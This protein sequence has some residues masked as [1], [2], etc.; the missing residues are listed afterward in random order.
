MGFLQSR[1]SRFLSFRRWRGRSSLVGIV[2]RRRFAF[3]V[4]PSGRVEVV[5]R[6]ARCIHRSAVADAFCAAPRAA[7]SARTYSMPSPEALSALHV[8]PCRLEKWMSSSW[9]LNP[10]SSQMLS[11]AVVMARGKWFCS[12]AWAGVAGCAGWV[13]RAA[14]SSMRTFSPRSHAALTGEM[15]LPLHHVCNMASMASTAV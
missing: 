11:G 15:S 3:L 2:S 12:P 13:A 10:K 8:T 4:L 9:G 14:R 7:R 6:Q 5:R 1:L